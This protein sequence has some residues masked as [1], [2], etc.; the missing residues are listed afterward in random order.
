MKWTIFAAFVSAAFSQQALS[1]QTA[2]PD[3]DVFFGTQK[4]GNVFPGST[5]PFGMVKMG[6]DTIGSSSGLFSGYANDGKIAGISMMH[7]SGTGGSPE[8]GV[9]SQLPLIGDID[10]STEVSLGRSSD[11]TGSVGYYA[12]NFDNE[13]KAEFAA[14]DRSGIYQYTFPQDKEPKI[15]VNVSHHLGNTNKPYWT[16]YFVNGSVEA[17]S[18]KNGYKG[19]GTFAGG[20][21]CQDPWTVYFCGDFENNADLVES[22]VGTKTSDSLQSS[23]SANQ[24][25]G[26]VFTFP[27]SKSTIR[28]R[29]GISFISTDQACQNIKDDFKD[30]NLNSTVSDTNT[31]WDD[32]V[33]GKIS[34]AKDNATLTNLMYTALYGAHLLP[35][36][37]TGEN[38]K[39]KSSE[40]YYDDWFTIW[41][42]FRC[43]N[44][45][46][47]VLSPSRGA[48]LIRSLIDTYKNDGYTPD[49]RSA[50][51]N[52]KT[53]GG[54]NS[55]ILMAD[56]YVKNVDNH[57]NWN[58]AFAAMVKNA[59]VSPPYYYDFKAPDDSTKEGRG[60]LSDWLNLGYVSRDHTRS[61]TRTMEYAY[62]DFALS[63]VAKGIG[64]A[65]AHEK[66]LKR[67]A[68]WQNI[69]NHD[70]SSLSCNYTGF[71]QPKKLDGSWA[72]DKYDPI[73]CGNCYW[74]DDEY[75]GKPVE[76]GWAVPHDIATLV[77][78]IG[79]ND[80]FITR[81]DDMFGLHGQ[82]FAD[83]GN[84]PSFLTP[85][86]YNFVNANYKTAETVRY[87]IDTKY[88]TGPSGLPGNSDAGSMQA[89]LIFG[90]LGFYPVAG[91]TTYLISSPFFSSATI[92]LENGDK[93]E[94]TASN[95]SSD[96]IYI[97]SVELNGKAW[98]KNWFTHDDLFKNGGSLH[99]ELGSSPARWDTGDVPPS[100]G[101][102]S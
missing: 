37:R 35:S 2:D 66:Y 75:E 43:L 51:Q 80:T 13:V 76:Y 40:P 78:F 88:S 77:D 32:Q 97:Q 34:V 1:Q 95:V 10:Y 65:T 93:V 87:L 92:N 38:P 36:N 68:N 25:M 29:V 98:D 4:G 69:W 64:N 45:L 94:I 21:A 101:H 99:F 19:Q 9:I 102:I 15:M 18:D 27:S 42:T 83:I 31:L 74:G 50:N 63:V 5:R 26:I 67:S 61:V 79:S 60:G 81:L 73:S 6:V 58:D 56:A 24:S 53:Q 28:S 3:V 54:S 70:A 59:E 39:W 41:D 84:E 85:Y 91:S 89:W 100:P 30:Y 11:D 23:G 55:D 44:P 47:N 16:Q 90:L 20:W 86:L 52:G 57:V 8:Y 72:D 49:G 46:F 62:D 33:F 12:C 17:N 22:F 71:V 48:E 82:S 7:E 96:N 14:A